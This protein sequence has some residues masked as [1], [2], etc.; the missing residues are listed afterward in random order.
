MLTGRA[1]F[2]AAFTHARQGTSLSAPAS[3]RRRGVARAGAGAGAGEGVRG[4]AASYYN[5]LKPFL[6]EQRAQ[7]KLT[8]LTTRAA[9]ALAARAALV[10][11]RRDETR[12]ILKYSTLK[13][14]SYNRGAPAYILTPTCLIYLL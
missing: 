13:E 14:G 3:A 6:K 12:A 7:G 8:L 9:A 5:I 11:F 1:P 2:K 10:A 4:R